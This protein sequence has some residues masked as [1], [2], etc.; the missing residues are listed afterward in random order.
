MKRFSITASLVC[1]SHHLSIFGRPRW[2][3]H[4]GRVTDCNWVGLS[5]S[6]DQLQS[7]RAH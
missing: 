5:P 1:V 2:S 3:S 4:L 7:V 6:L